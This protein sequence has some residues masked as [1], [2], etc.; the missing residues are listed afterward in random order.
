MSD[1][2][3]E[4]CTICLCELEET[5]N[6]YTNVCNHFYHKGCIERWLKNSSNCPICKSKIP[7]NKELFPDYTNDTNECCDWESEVNNM[8]IDTDEYINSISHIPM[9]RN[10]LTQNT[11]RLF[12]NIPSNSFSHTVRNNSNRRVD[13]SNAIDFLN[14]YQN[15]IATNITISDENFTNINR[16]INGL[17]LLIDRPILDRPLTRSEILGDLVI[18]IINVEVINMSTFRPSMR[19]YISALNDEINNYQPVIIV[20]RE[21]TESHLNFMRVNYPEIN[22][23]Q[24]ITIIRS[25]D[26]PINNQGLNTTINHQPDIISNRIIDHYRVEAFLDTTDVMN[27]NSTN[28]SEERRLIIRDCINSLRLLLNRINDNDLTYLEK[29]GMLVLEIIS[30]QLPDINLFISAMNNYINILNIVSINLYVTSNHTDVPPLQHVVENSNVRHT[31]NIRNVIE[32]TRVSL[33]AMTSLSRFIDNDILQMGSTEPLSGSI[34][35]SQ[36]STPQNVNPNVSLTSN[37][38]LPNYIIQSISHN[39]R[40]QLLSFGQIHARRRD[41]PNSNFQPMIV[42]GENMTFEDSLLSQNARINGERNILSPNGLNSF[43]DFYSDTDST[44]L[45]LNR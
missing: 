27:D 8:E 12:R 7:I 20:S 44:F 43:D 22:Y 9:I 37:H 28:I 2:D 30:E 29:A 33:R 6:K 4:K 17:Y 19:E 10:G 15:Y 42:R 35:V 14:F 26:T 38:I 39:S 23:S 3:C 36:E 1:N 13:R 25:V 5:V 18:E 34:S 16:G 11:F 41:L 31:R 24:D 21:T 40:E 32:D 45:R